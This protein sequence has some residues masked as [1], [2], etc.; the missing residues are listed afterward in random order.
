[1]NKTIRIERGKKIV[2]NLK[3]AGIRITWEQVMQHCQN[4]LP[5]RPRIAEVLVV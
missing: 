5:S 1:M 4:C 2:E 3:N